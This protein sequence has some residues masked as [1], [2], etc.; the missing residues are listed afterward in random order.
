MI[1]FPANTLRRV[2]MQ[3]LQYLDGQKYSSHFDYFHDTVSFTQVEIEVSQ[4][5]LVALGLI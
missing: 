1:L 4:L 2:C 3:V 5:D